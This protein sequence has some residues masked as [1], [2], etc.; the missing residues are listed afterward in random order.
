MQLYGEQHGGSSKIKHRGAPVVAQQVK[1]LTGLP[2]SVGSVPGLPQ[3][4]KD[5]QH[6]CELWCRSRMWLGSGIA[7]AVVQASSCSSNSIP[8][9]GTSI[10]C[11][12]GP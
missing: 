1:N 6:C 11:A 7:V 8:S 5:I 12:C 9:L 4:V 3:W 2:E 10:C